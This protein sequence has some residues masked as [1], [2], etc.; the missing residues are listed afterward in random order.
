MTAGGWNSDQ[1]SPRIPSA[2]VQDCRSTNAPLRFPRKPG[3]A[4]SKSLFGGCN[5]GA[6][7]LLDGRMVARH[8][9]PMTPF[10]ADLTGLVAPGP[11]TG[12]K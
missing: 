11:R 5:Y 10:E 7:V 2:A 9:A 6:E 3:I 4:W 8:F 1:Q 12:C